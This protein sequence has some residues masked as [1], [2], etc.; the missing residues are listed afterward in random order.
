MNLSKVSSDKVRLENAKAQIDNFSLYTA[1][2]LY[3]DEVFDTSVDAFSFGL[4]LYEM[5][6][7]APA[8][9]PK[10]PEEASKMICL[11]RLR[12]PLKIK[13]KSYPLDVKELI[14]ECWNPEPVI[15]PTFS[16]II[17]RLDKVYAICAKQGRWK[18]TFKLPWK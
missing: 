3:K 6:E 13:S 12:P 18:D 16:E 4:I 15:R 17:I 7:G 14:E 1:P 2:E 11:D 10:S 5:I 9:H 8:F